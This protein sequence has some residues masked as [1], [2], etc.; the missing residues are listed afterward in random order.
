MVGF[1][2]FFMHETRLDIADG[3]IDGLLDEDLVEQERL[4][5]LG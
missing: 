5:G 4:D 1:E 3:L 2:F